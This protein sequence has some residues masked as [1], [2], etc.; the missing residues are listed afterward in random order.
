MLCGRGFSSGDSEPSGRSLSISVP[1]VPFPADGP[2]T[3]DLDALPADTR[4]A[5]LFALHLPPK[6][7]EPAVLRPSVDP[8]SVAAALWA[9]DD[10]AELGALA[11]W[12]EAWQGTSPR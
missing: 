8:A 5:K 2:R 1:R 3:S 10:G 6:A 7:F 12:A 9:H 4:L 11:A